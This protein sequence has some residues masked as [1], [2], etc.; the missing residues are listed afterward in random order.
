[1]LYDRVG[2]CID[3]LIEGLVVIRGVMVEGL[4]SFEGM[5]YWIVDY[6]GILKL[7]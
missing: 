1:M 7:V 3:W 4:F 2:V 5:Y 6:D